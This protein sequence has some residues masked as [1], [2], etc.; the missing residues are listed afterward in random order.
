MTVSEELQ[1][2][3][4]LYQATFEDPSWLDTPRTV[5]FG[6]DPSA[7][8]LHVG[9]LAAFMPLRHLLDHGWKVILLVG[10]A[11][12]MI[13]DP[14]GKSEERNLQSLE[15]IAHNKAA[16]AEQVKKLF[17]GK[18]F[19]LVDNYDWL[20][21]IS[22]LEFLRD[23]GKHYGMSTL[24]QRDYI[25][26]RIGEGGAGISYT[27][28]SYTLLQGYDYYHLHQEHGAELQYGGSDQWGNMLS[29]VDL[30]RKK[31]GDETHVLAGPLII[32]KSTGKKFGK[33]EAGAVWLDPDKTSPFQFYQFWLNADDEG[34]SDY[35]RYFTL[36]PKDEIE[37]LVAEHAQSPEKRL[38][39]TR[40]AEEV[41][42]M[43]YGEQVLATVQKVTGIIFQNRDPDDISLDEIK[44][45][46]EE[47]PTIELTADNLAEKSLADL[48]IE[49]QLASSK[50][51][52]RE[53]LA[54]GAIRLNGEI[55]NEE[56]IHENFVKNN[57]TLIRRGKNKVGLL[58]IS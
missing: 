38:A 16:V 51:E 50:R 52:A 30:I 49:L 46:S 18:D 26:Q 29:G 28:F 20:S 5:Y 34:V 31:T 56:N 8:S 7:D 4:F 33:S 2:R 37:Q 11:T 10:G 32:N 35:L 55:T 39:Q 24:V 53:F 47:L 6:V 45:L 44:V 40:L 15:Q 13:G 14:G 22:L 41:T 58:R 23:I 12:G 54:A 3:G 36:L 27:E 1:W 9:N 57:I 42:R 19:T 43:I 21:K 25:A 48:L 17:D